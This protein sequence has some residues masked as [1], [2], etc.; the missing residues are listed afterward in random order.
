LPRYFYLIIYFKGQVLL[1]LFLNCR[2]NEII[3]EGSKKSLVTLTAPSTT[4]AW[5]AIQASL[6]YKAHDGVIVDGQEFWFIDRVEIT[7]EN[8]KR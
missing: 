4:E 8:D 5:E 7:L 6:E 3:E 2:E 1:Y